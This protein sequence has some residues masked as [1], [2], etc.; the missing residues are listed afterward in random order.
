MVFPTGPGLGLGPGPAGALAWARDR[1]GL[2]PGFGQGPGPAGTLA[3]EEV[4]QPLEADLII[5]FDANAAN[6]KG[7][8]F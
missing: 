7:K 1:P 2:G 6:V 8:M 4:H 3:C 5:F